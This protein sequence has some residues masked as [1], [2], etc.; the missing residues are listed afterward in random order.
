MTVLEAVG[1]YLQAQGVGTLGTN[2]FLAV[3]PEAPEACVCVYETPG[4]APMETMG[5]AGI[6]VDRSG[7]Q[8]IAR[9]AR[10]DYPG[11]RDKAQTVRT[12]LAAVVEQTLSGVHVLR[13]TPDGAFLPM[14][15][16]P[17]GCPMVSVN[18]SCVVRP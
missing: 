1:D 7:L 13:I 4:F 5:S 15:E 6:A 10:G 8:V 16:G 12:L 2:V 17:D 3:M 11:A 9:G 14:G 18:F